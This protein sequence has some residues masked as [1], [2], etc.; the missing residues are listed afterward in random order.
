[1]MDKLQDIIGVLLILGLLLLIRRI[2][3]P[4]RLPRKQQARRPPTKD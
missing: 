2:F 3:L 4:E 1:M